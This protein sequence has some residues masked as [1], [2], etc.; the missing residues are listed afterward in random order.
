MRYMGLNGIN[1]DKWDMDGKLPVDLID[2]R[3]LS[4]VQF[5][6]TFLAVSWEDGMDQF[7]MSACCDVCDGDGKWFILFGM[8][9]I[10]NVW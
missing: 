2:D 4:L 9:Q 7:M 8:P 5:D 3:S 6:G 1:T 10:M